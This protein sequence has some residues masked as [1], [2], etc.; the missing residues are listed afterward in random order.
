MPLSMIPSI[1]PYYIMPYIMWQ[2]T[3]FKGGVERQLTS[4]QQLTV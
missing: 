2:R 3:A 1:A 4:L